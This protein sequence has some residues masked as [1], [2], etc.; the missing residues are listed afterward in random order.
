ML[1]CNWIFLLVSPLLNSRRFSFTSRKSQEPLSRSV[2]SPPKAVPFLKQTMGE[3]ESQLWTWLM[4]SFKEIIKHIYFSINVSCKFQKILYCQ[5]LWAYLKKTTKELLFRKTAQQRWRAYCLLIFIKLRDAGHVKMPILSSTKQVRIG[6]MGHEISQNTFLKK[7]LTWTGT[8]LKKLP[9]DFMGYIGYSRENIHP[10]G[11][12]P[13][14]GGRA[15]KILE[16]TILSSIRF[17]SI[18]YKLALYIL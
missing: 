6:S 3:Q 13:G 17:S 14:G 2:S 12:Y 7:S 15:H 18:C 11:V 8:G 16:K 5:A 9:K 1:T 10:F 4:Q